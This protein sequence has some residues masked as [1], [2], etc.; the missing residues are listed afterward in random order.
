M[1]VI[2]TPHDPLQQL[3]LDQK[4]MP[5]SLKWT[6]SCWATADF[7]THVTAAVKFTLFLESKES[8][9]EEP[10]Q[11]SKILETGKPLST[12]SSEC[13][14]PWFGGR[15]AMRYLPFLVQQHHYDIFKST[16]C[17]AAPPWFIDHRSWI[18]IWVQ[19]FARSCLGIPSI[20]LDQG[21]ASWYCQLWVN[22]ENGDNVSATVFL[23]SPETLGDSEEF[24]I[25]TWQLSWKCVNVW[26]VF[27]KFS[28]F[29]YSEMSCKF[30]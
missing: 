4:A 13:S 19:A 27:D 16:S 8:V 28:Y 5:R 20:Y 3:H 23:A 2:S 12:L 25:V 21:H 18:G 29:K 15:C 9:R 6:D 30:I 24:E 10:V 22:S 17:C 26:C 14:K 7:M 1:P 11:C